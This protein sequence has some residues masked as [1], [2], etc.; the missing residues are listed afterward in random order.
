MIQYTTNEVLTEATKR[1]DDSIVIKIK[2]EDIKVKQE[3][4]DVKIL[5]EDVDYN[6]HNNIDL[7]MLLGSHVREEKTYKFK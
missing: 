4:N 6:L 2:D 1:F 7:V 5:I 3:D